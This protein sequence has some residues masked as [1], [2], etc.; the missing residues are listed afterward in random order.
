MKAVAALST[1]VET[2]L[3]TIESQRSV[4]K[5]KELKAAKSLGINYQALYAANVEEFEYLSFDGT[6]ELSAIVLDVFGRAGLNE[7]QSYLPRIS[8]SIEYTCILAGVRYDSKGVFEYSEGVLPILLGFLWFKHS[9][10]RCVKRALSS[11]NL[12][13]VE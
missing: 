8:S 3:K 6:K 12:T 1:R 13:V 10:K 7:L 5:A 11:F 4:F 2:G 9:D